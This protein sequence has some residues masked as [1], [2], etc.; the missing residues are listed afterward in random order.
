MCTVVILRR[1]GA[2][3]PLILSANRDEMIDRPWRPPGRHWLERAD[4]VAGMDELAGGT[5]LGLNDAGVVAGVMN[6]QGALGPAPDKRSRGELV[7]E[8]LDHADAEHAAEALRL[9]DGEAYRPFN[10][11]IA[12]DRDAYWLKST[13]D[14]PVEAAPIGPGLSMLTSRDLNDSASGRVAA[15]LPRFEQAA[16][17]DPATNNWSEW[18][19][20]MASGIPKPGDQPRSAMAIAPIEGYG[21]VSGSLIALPRIG[22]DAH[23]VWRFC[24]GRPGTAPYKDITI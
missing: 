23:A 12:D 24:G 21:T 18:E 22:S 1:P 14:G 19:E 5:W 4:V 17:P 11:V 8:A 6:R 2:D 15:Y 9:L 3:W 7:L 16:A 20:L 13:G 10:L